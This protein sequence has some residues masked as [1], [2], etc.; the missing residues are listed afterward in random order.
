MA[1]GVYVPIQT[2]TVTDIGTTNV[3][4]NADAALIG[5]TFDALAIVVSDQLERID[6][7]LG[8]AEN[9]LTELGMPTN[10]TAGIDDV[11]IV[12]VPPVDLTTF[13]NAPTSG[14]LPGYDDI[15]WGAND[16]SISTYSSDIYITILEKVLD[17]IEN[18]GTGISTDV[19]DAI[20]ERNLEKQRVANEKAYNLGIAEISSRC[21]SFPQYASQALANQVSIEILKQSHNSANEIEISM[22]E[23]AQKNMNSML[24]RGAALEGVLR[25][26]WKDYNTMKLTAVKAKTDELIAHVE[27]I[28]KERDGIL[29]LFEAEAAIFKASTEGQKNWYEAISENQK[30]QLQKSALELQKIEAE[31]KAKLDAYIAVNSLREKILATSGGV[32]AQVAASAMNAENVSIG[33]SVSNGFSRS[34]SFDHRESKSISADQRISESHDFNAKGQDIT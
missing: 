12:P 34:E 33:Y 5:E 32:S 8:A 25:A 26:F 17:G 18:G 7:T 28:T 4:P 31:L 1:D 20:H 11:V 30:A 2:I 24:D 15:I 19:E 14:D 9:L 23:L 6:T 10:W 3:T 16:T 29:R 27:S 13:P 22:A 21:L